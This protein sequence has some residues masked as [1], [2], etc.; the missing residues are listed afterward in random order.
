MASINTDN[1]EQFYERFSKGQDKYA[2]F[3]GGV[4][5]KTDYESSKGNRE[6]WQDVSLLYHVRKNDA[7][8]VVRRINYV[9]KRSYDP[10]R[11]AGNASG[12]NYY[13]YNEINNF[14]YLC[15]SSNSLNRIDLFGTN[16]STYTPSF[17]SEIE[18]TYP[19]GY[20]WRKLY[21]IDSSSKRFLTDNLMPVNDAILDYEEYPTATSLEGLANTICTG[22]PGVSGACGLY[23]RKKEYDPSSSTYTSSGSLWD[24]FVD[25]HC[26]RCYELSQRLNMEYR[27]IAGGEA[28]DLPSS[29][30]VKSNLTKIQESQLNPNSNEKIQAGLTSYSQGNDGEI[31]SILIN[32]SSLTYAQRIVS[33]ANPTIQITSSTGSGA[34]ARLKTFVDTSGN[35]VVEGVELIDG[36][37]GYYDYSLSIPSIS[38]SS[39]FLNVLEINIEPVDGYAT[40]SRKLLNCTQV[41]FKVELDS[42]DIQDLSLGQTTFKTY[43][44][45]KNPETTSDVVF[46]SDLNKNQKKLQSNVTRLIVNLGV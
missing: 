40:S 35:N 14:V 24:T 3:L 13:V 26:W 39:T 43:G 22:A 18:K 31:L 38:N 9:R 11:S 32:L 6:T 2:F 7:K 4:S 8:P 25:V 36:G 17:T 23:A 37:S 41:A 30:T 16:N 5:E 42:Q 44:I 45:L 10:W 46:G 12:Q 21:K 29:I 15:V 19:D 20:R 33:T 28:S 1:L 27:F 34:S